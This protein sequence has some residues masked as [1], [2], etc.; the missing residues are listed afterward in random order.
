[1]GGGAEALGGG[2][3][4][5]RGKAS[6]RKAKKRVGFRLDMTPLVD[7]TFLL[8]TFFMLTTSMSQPQTMELSVPPQETEIDVAMSK[9]L[10]IRLRDDG[11]IFYNMGIDAPEPVTLDQLQRVV[12]DQNVELINECIVTYKTA[13]NVPYGNFIQLLDIINQAEVEIIS[14][15]RASGISERKRKFTI[16]D[17]TDKDIEEISGL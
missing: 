11:K 5:K 10:T 1:M 2:P 17:M 12:I 9:L 6:K 3:K 4:Q 14:G 7:I 13:R 15:L 8:L 16:A